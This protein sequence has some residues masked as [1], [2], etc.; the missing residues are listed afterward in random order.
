MKISVDAPEFADAVAWTATFA[1]SNPAVPALSGILIDATGDKLVLT[2]QDHNTTARRSVAGSVATPGKALVPAKLFANL[3]AKMPQEGQTDLVLNGDQFSVSAAGSKFRLRRMDPQDFPMG[4]DTGPTPA[5]LNVAGP[6]FAAVLGRVAPFA[7]TD[8]SRPI[9]TG[10]RLSLAGGRITA[11]ATDSYRMAIES[12]PV[13]TSTPDRTVVLPSKAAQLAARAVQAADEVVMELSDTAYRVSAGEVEVAGAL[14]EGKYPD[15]GVLIPDGEGTA[16][17]AD[18]AAMR[19]VVERFGVLDAATK[20]LVPAT[21]SVRPGEPL[22]IHA[23]SPEAG[24]GV[25]HVDAEVTGGAV[26]ISF[27]PT[28]LMSVLATV[29]ADRVRF[30]LRDELKPAL[31][32][33][34]DPA[35]DTDG[36]DA[37]GGSDLRMILM[38]MRVG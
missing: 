3:L 5:V 1:P 13:T 26:A 38:P 14:L 12:L 27:N 20:G 15:V 24:D 2:C 11:A 7:S 19:T 36:T 22:E 16:M 21:L 25:D 9:L 31:V 6:A 35:L 33:P 34:A 18:V 28:F 23:D 4:Y 17:V 32:T 10:V 29:P 30:G 37:V 8:S